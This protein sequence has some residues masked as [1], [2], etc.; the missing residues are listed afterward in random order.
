MIGCSCPAIDPWAVRKLIAGSE[1]GWLRGIAFDPTPKPSGCNVG[2]GCCQNLPAS[3]W[4]FGRECPSPRGVAPARASLVL[5]RPGLSDALQGKPWL[6]SFVRRQHA[7]LQPILVQWPQCKCP[8]GSPAFSLR[9][10]PSPKEP[11]AQSLEHGG[12]GNALNIEF[13]ADIGDRNVLS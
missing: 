12:S 8:A 7:D 2:P 10:S 1:P 13:P 3:V 5:N 9:R 6:E 11:R 4:R